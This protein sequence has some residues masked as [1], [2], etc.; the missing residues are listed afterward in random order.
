MTRALIIGVTG[1]DGSLLAK[2]LYER[3]IEVHGTF[4]RGASDKFWRINELGI[5]DKL[6]YH[7]YNVGNELAFSET[8]RAVQPDLVFSL[9]GESFTALSFEEPKQFMSVNIESVVEQLE[10]VRAHAPKAKIFFAGSSEIFGEC[11]L[12]FKLNETSSF[13]PKTPYGVSKLTQHYLVQLYREKYSLSLFNGI[14][15]PHESPFRSAEFVTRKIV[16]GLTHRKFG[17]GQP[18]QLGD[19]SMRR[20]WGNAVDYV[21]WMYRLLTNGDPGDYVF[22]TGV[23]TS[24]EEFLLTAAAAMD[25]RLEKRST[26][27]EG[28][29]EYFE[30][31]SGKL[32][33]VS[34]V[35]KFGANRFSYGA[36]DTSKLQRVLGHSTAANI[37]N[38]A[39]QMVSK[40][41]FRLTGLLK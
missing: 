31:V 5:R 27:T 29:F 32:Y 20:D 41:I 25:V 39:E 7:I 38:L 16:V 19:L 10:A 21:D 11:P 28:V 15:F 1:Q 24:V 34:D 14:L 40:E 12:G 4:R 9:A 36:A 18:L 8:V 30:K 33:A 2:N 22:G 35:D 37:E 6:S 13:H 3:G 26:N 23:N 17:T